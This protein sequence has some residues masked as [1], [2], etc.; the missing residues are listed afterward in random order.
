MEKAT[1]QQAL[2]EALNARKQRAIEE[3]KGRLRVSLGVQ[4]GKNPRKKR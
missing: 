4:K 3:K 1:A 2:E